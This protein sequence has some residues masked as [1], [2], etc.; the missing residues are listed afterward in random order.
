MILEFGCLF[1]GF[2]L[3]DSNGSRKMVNFFVQNL[4]QHP[5]FFLTILTTILGHFATWNR[6]NEHYMTCNC[7]NI[8]PWWLSGLCD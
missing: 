6:I 5:I 2:L 3:I 1:F 4:V 7:K 8:Q